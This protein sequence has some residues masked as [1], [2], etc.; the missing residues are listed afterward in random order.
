MPEAGADLVRQPIRIA[1]GR[2]FPGQLF[3]RLLRCQAG[4]GG[5]PG[6]L[7]GQLIQ[8][9]PTPVGDLE[10][11]PQCV[12]MSGEQAMHLRRPLQV[13]VGGPLALEADVVDRAA[14]PYAGQDVL[15]NAAVG[16]MEQD[17]VGDDGLHAEPDREL[18]QLVQSHLIAG[19]TAQG[20]RAIG[21]R[22]ED[23]GKGY[24]PSAARAV[25]L[26]RHERGDQ[27]LGVIGHIGPVEMTGALAGPTLA[28]REKPTEP[29]VGRPVGW[30]DEEVGAVGQL[31]PTPD[32]QPDAG[33]LGGLVGPHDAGDAVDVRDRQ[34][35]ESAS[36]GLGEQ[37]VAPARP[38]QE[39]EVRGAL[40][41]GIAR[42]GHNVRLMFLSVVEYESRPTPAQRPGQLS[43]PRMPSWVSMVGGGIRVA[44]SGVS[45]TPKR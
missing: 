26:I 43:T 25:G 44:P 38:T 16:V 22:A 34:R 12:G 21:I 7:I 14:L 4:E 11:A 23:A 24:E 36:C 42:G 45:G 33:R 8:T 6:I 27:A 32:D 15:E 1:R 39:R 35:L 29:A 18:G 13:T 3:Q 28:E 40:K 17:V 5:L 37:L 20:Q 9:E 19:T 30:I 10:R 41:F 31:K 2:T